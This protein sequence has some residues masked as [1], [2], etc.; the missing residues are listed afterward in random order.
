M[1]EVVQPNRLFHKLSHM[2]PESPA[3][4]HAGHATPVPLAFQLPSVTVQL[5]LQFQRQLQ[6]QL[7]LCNCAIAKREIVVHSTTPARRGP[8]LVPLSAAPYTALLTALPEPSGATGRLHR[9]LAQLGLD[10]E[11]LR[12]AGIRLATVDTARAAYTAAGLD[13]AQAQAHGLPGPAEVQ[14]EGRSPKGG[15]PFQLFGKGRQPV[16]VFPYHNPLGQIVDLATQAPPTR[17]RPALRF[18]LRGPYNSRLSRMPYGGWDRQRL[19]HSPTVI[20][21]QGELAQLQLAQMGHAALGLRP[22]RDWSNLYLE[23]LQGKQVRL[24]L[25]N[26][27]AGRALTEWLLARLPTHL[28]VQVLDPRWYGAE[29]DVADRSA[30]LYQTRLPR[31]ILEECWL[32][33]EAWRH[34]CQELPPAQTRADRRR[35]RGPTARQLQHITRLATAQVWLAAR[36]LWEQAG[37]DRQG[38][39]RLSLSQLMERTG[40]SRPAV[41]GGLRQARAHGL[42]KRQPEHPGRTAVYRHVTPLPYRLSPAGLLAL[43]D[44]AL[45]KAALVVAHQGLSSSIAA[46]ARRLGHTWRLARRAW[47]WLQGGGFAQL[48]KESRSQGATT[49]KQIAQGLKPGVNPAV[50]PGFS[51]PLGLFS[52]L[53]D[54]PDGGAGSSLAGAFVTKDSM[55]SMNPPDLVTAD[56][57]SA[58]LQTLLLEIGIYSGKASELIRTT[59]PEQLRQHLRSTRAFAPAAPALWLQSALQRDWPLPDRALVRQCRQLGVGPGMTLRLLTAHPERV[60]QQLAWLPLRG[61]LHNAPGYLV[62][63]VFEDRPPPPTPA[64]EAIPTRPAAPGAAPVVSPESVPAPAAYAAPPLT[65]P[66]LTELCFARP[67]LI[68]LWRLC[69]AHVEG[70]GPGAVLHLTVPHERA[71]ELLLQGDLWQGRSLARQGLSWIQ[72]QLVPQAETLEVAVEVDPALQPAWDWPALAADMAAAVESHTRGTPERVELAE[73]LARGRAAWAAGPETLSLRL[74]RPLTRREKRAVSLSL[75]ARHGAAASWD[76]TV[77]ASLR[78]RAAEQAELVAWLAAV[79][80]AQGEDVTDVE[81][82]VQQYAQRYGLEFLWGICER[83]QAQRDIRKP[84]GWFRWACEHYGK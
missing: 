52:A 64:P 2:V 53:R 7:Q 18:G 46:L 71:R 79:A 81:S 38:T 4:G 15:E 23:L 39:L 76:L 55:E 8:P 14:G 54:D 44:L 84:I 24:A 27:A 16:L 12:A 50:T 66:V 68:A 72:L 62:T 6:H 63:A 73:L 40:L 29:E 37:Y 48:V 26:D 59:P 58:P 43:D 45:I 57:D 5:Q 41:I 61:D 77:D 75:W 3:A 21:T 34:R 51:Q 67:E 20:L 83:L 74:G 11:V 47:Q 42:L 82:V 60:R 33:V 22:G 19:Q 32:E 25:P 78:D 13:A 56:T 30:S 31:V 10:P 69:Q 28:P 49:G 80:R 70:A 9:W 1:L 35:H 36:E 17:R 65:D